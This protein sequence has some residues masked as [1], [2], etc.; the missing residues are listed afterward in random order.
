LKGVILKSVPRF[1][2]RLQFMWKSS[3][4]K[5]RA[6]AQT[7]S[8]LDFV[9]QNLDL[10]LRFCSNFDCSGGGKLK[11]GIYFSRNTS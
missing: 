1:Y 9:R 3:M 7:S 4:V 8:G 11:L 2:E 5:I 10:S 6:D